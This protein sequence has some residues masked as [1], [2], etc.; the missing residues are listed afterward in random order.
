MGILL[1]EKDPHSQQPALVVGGR[2]I[3]L[4]RDSLDRAPELVD[5]IKVLPPQHRVDREA[6]RFPVGIK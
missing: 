2:Q 1:V 3:P 4:G 6:P 5:V